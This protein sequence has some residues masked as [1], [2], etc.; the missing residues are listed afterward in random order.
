MSTPAQS[1]PCGR[2]HVLRA[3]RDRAGSGDW[4]RRQPL[5]F[6][7][8]VSVLRSPMGLAGVLVVLAVRRR[9]RS[10][11]PL[12]APYPPYEQHQGQLLQPPSAAVP[13]RHR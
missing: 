5:T 13:A 6:Q 8:T 2:A 11:A 10:F 3:P 4:L 9:S 1:L 12:V 7:A